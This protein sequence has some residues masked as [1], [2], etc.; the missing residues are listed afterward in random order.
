M[1]QLFWFDLCFSSFDKGMVTSVQAGMVDKGVKFLSG[2]TP[3]K[4]LKQT[5]RKLLVEW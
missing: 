4:I 2:K 1:K 5:N 3:D